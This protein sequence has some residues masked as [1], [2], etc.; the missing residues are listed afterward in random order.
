MHQ[1]VRE[2]AERP[3]ATYRQQMQYLRKTQ[4]PSNCP[5]E[6]YQRDLTAQLQEWRANGDSIIL[7]GDFNEDIN[8]KLETMLKQPGIELR[9]VMKAKHP[10]NPL[11]LTHYEGSRPIDGIFATPDIKVKAAA[12]LAKGRGIGD[13]RTMVIDL[14][15]KFV[16][17]NAKTKKSRPQPEG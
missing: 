7:A 2:G 14:P 15:S 6:T 1:P 4:D 3:T 17:G 5:R 13:H 9:N 11:L 10:K 16:M 12:Y 8:G